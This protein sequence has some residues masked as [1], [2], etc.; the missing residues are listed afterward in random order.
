LRLD[1]S[2][3][4]WGSRLLFFRCGDLVVEVSHE[5]ASEITDGPDR[6]WGL[7]W[8]VLDVAASHARLEAAGVP[9]SPLRVGRKPGT[10]LFTV[11][12]HAAWVPTAFIGK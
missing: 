11:R 3:P 4:A 8:G 5:L 1:R 10:R 9:V 2:N 6:L 12:D 7:T